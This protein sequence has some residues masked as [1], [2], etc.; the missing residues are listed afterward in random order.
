M[1]CEASY[2]SLATVWRKAAVRKFISISFKSR[3]YC[4]P[5]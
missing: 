4:I 5:S 2:A 1:V 3:N